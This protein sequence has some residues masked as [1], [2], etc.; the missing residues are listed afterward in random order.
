MKSAL[1]LSIGFGVLLALGGV[2]ALGWLSGGAQAAVPE[3]F[4]LDFSGS[5]L[6]EDRVFSESGCEV[7][8]ALYSWL[9]L[10][11]GFELSEIPQRNDRYVLRGQ[12]EACN[13]L[14][15][16]TTSTEGHISFEAGRAE[17]K[18]YFAAAPQPGVGCGGLEIDWTPEPGG[19][20]L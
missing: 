17:G 14:A 19:R 13:A 12:P 5:G 10:S 7:T 11:P 18:W 3:T 8:V 4:E 6:V 1:P 2:L 15:V 20:V 9:S 16:A